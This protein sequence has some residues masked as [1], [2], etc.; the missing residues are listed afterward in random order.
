[1]AS[2]GKKFI[3]Q[4]CHNEGNAPPTARPPKYHKECYGLARRRAPGSDLVPCVHCHKPKPKNTKSGN[5]GL[6]VE[7]FALSRVTSPDKPIDEQLLDLLKR[8][9]QTPRDLAYRVG[10]TPGKVLDA[11]LAMQARGVNLHN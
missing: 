5:T 3:C 11:L 6:C 2:E 4:Y 7:C 10:G 8:G 9:E 1:M